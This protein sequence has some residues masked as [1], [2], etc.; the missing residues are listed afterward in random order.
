MPGDGSELNLMEMDWKSFKSHNLLIN[1][2]EK[3]SIL[4]AMLLNKAAFLESEMDHK[5]TGLCEHRTRLWCSFMC[6]ARNTR[7]HYSSKVGKVRHTF[8]SLLKVFFVSNVSSLRPVEMVDLDGLSLP[9]LE[10]PLGEFQLG[11]L[12]LL[13]LSM[14][15]RNK[16]LDILKV[17]YNR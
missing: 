7:L 8:Q 5:S 14:K 16:D 9:C 1:D 11:P 15:E 6:N 2:V 13:F 12:F 17:C 4:Y 3:L 10:Y